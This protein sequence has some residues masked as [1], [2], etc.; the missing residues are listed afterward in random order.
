MPGIPESSPVPRRHLG[1]IVLGGG[2]LTHL[3]LGVFYSWPVFVVLFSRE[4]YGYSY[5]SMKLIFSI[6]LFIMAVSMIG[7]GFLMNSLGARKMGIIGGLILGTSYI[8][9]GFV[10]SNIWALGFCISIGAGTG[11]GMVYMA[12]ISAGMKWLPEFKGLFTGVPIMAYGFGS[13]LWVKLAGGARY[14]FLEN[15]YIGSLDTVSSILVLFGILFLILVCLGS[16]MLIEP[17]KDQVFVM[18]TSPGKMLGSGQ[19]YMIFFS[20]FCSVLAGLLV[21][22]C[23]RLYAT[24]ALSLA[25]FG[26][27]SPSHENKITVAVISGSAMAW[28]AIANGLGRIGWGALSMATGTRLAVF[29][30][31]LIQGGA[32]VLL[33]L[34]GVSGGLTS[35]LLIILAVIIGFNFGGGFALYP[36]L[37]ADRFGVKFIAANYGIMFLAYFLAGVGGPWIAGDLK[38]AAKGAESL[39]AWFTPFA[40]AG[41]LAVA[42]S[43]LVFFLPRSNKE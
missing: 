40:L 25:Q 5:I 9:A 10:S 31:T 20:F 39:S 34:I 36:A 22:Y 11:M 2:T 14:G 1:W 35:A 32:F 43:V 6:A 15:F 3:A 42:A 13:M 27:L 19:F 38:L 26:S 7:A 41:T 18:Q 4:P 16:L 37:T 30:M 12:P 24:D 17:G 8:L 29:I 33:Y 21:I 23:L 28:Y